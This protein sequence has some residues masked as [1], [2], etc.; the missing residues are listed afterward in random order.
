MRSLSSWSH[1]TPASPPN[2]RLATLAMVIWPGVSASAT[3]S[4]ISAATALPSATTQHGFMASATH[5]DP[6]P[7]RARQCA[8]PATKCCK[9]ARRHRSAGATAGQST[10]F[11]AANRARPT[12]L[13]SRC[14][15][16]TAASA[17]GAHLAA[18][19]RASAN[20]ACNNGAAAAGQQRLV[21]A[22]ATNWPLCTTG[23]GE[24]S[25]CS[26]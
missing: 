21:P 5:A 22:N 3:I 20:G 14:D 18:A 19:S 4:A 11:T 24:S 13:L 17:A 8:T 16:H 6:A 10:G 25:S 9:S 23:G 2:D 15:R 7:A 1:S 12:E 26:S